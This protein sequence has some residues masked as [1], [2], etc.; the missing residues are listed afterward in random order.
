M[1]CLF[2]K[3]I[4]ESELPLDET[5]TYYK[6]DD[7]WKLYD[8]EQTIA[9]GGSCD[10]LKVVHKQT[11]KRWAAKE[12][13]QF[14]HKVE[15]LFQ[16]EVDI[17]KRIDEHP[18]II[19]F[20]NAYR[21]KRNFFIVTSF[22]SGGELFDRIVEKAKKQE[23]SERM[24]ANIVQMMLSSLKHLHD[25]N[26]VHRDLKPENF[27][28]ETSADDSNIRML[29]F[30][31]AII[32][33]EE[34]T[35]KEMCGT[36]YYMPREA[37]LN[38][39]R[40]MNA[41]K[42]GDMF[43]VGVITYIMMSGIPPFPGNTDDEIFERIKEGSWEPPAH[44]S[45]S[46][47][48]QEFVT[49]CLQTK[50]MARCTV[51]EALYNTWVTGA[52]AAKEP[53]DLQVLGSLRKFV[54]DSKLQK[55]IVNLMVKNVEED[56]EENLRRMF[57]RLDKDGDE[58]ITEEE[59]VASLKND[60][61]Y[62]PQAEREAKK[63][64]QDADENGDNSVNFEEFILAR[65]RNKL[66]TDKQVLYAVFNLLDSNGDEKVDKEELM[67]IFGNPSLGDA[68][69]QQMINEVDTDQDGCISFQEFMQTLGKV[70]DRITQRV[71]E[72]V[73]KSQHQ[74]E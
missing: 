21:D 74:K 29:D 10:V 20:H 40:G 59:M 61:M 13:H 39:K 60:G 23:F 19:V 31:S 24:C 34:K 50:P 58:R 63:I 42:Q 7:F 35:Y 15:K 66:T 6:V 41:L 27:V 30:G 3:P 14:K 28:F 57:N 62:G 48:L 65:A 67:T 16:R 56:D 52:T 17:L 11:G 55:A 54:K 70:G 5:G 2:E 51:D 53:V 26:I 44:V 18:N 12:L 46:K 1:G 69:I 4:D 68:E 64:L 71:R 47:G 22:L 73:E 36:P 9:K 38:T 37:V 8:Y 49:R 32:C 33:E 43:A 45:W 72:S 25:N